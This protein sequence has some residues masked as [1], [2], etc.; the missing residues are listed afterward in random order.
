MR[1]L[2][3][4]RSLALLCLWAAGAAT[5]LIIIAFLLSRPFEASAAALC[6]VVFVVPG[7]LFLRYW[8]RLYIRD[9]ALAHAA[10][11][12][13]EEGIV[14]ARTLGRKLKVPEADA[15]KILTTSI[16]EGHA[17]GELDERGR[18]VSSTTPRCPACGQPRPR[19]PEATRCPACG[20]AL[21]GGG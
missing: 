19:V 3:L 13:D 9:V 11:V 5:I 12:A 14:D 21:Q 2:S 16:R 20:A 6:A 8:R 10:K 7:L 17:K 4:Y 1:R 15:M 18:Y